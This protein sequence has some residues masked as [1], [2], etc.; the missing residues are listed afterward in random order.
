MRE[1]DAHVCTIYM[2][3]K[4]PNAYA[5]L[6]RAN[7]L[8]LSA[9]RWAYV[10][11]GFFPGG[12]FSRWAFVRIP[13][14]SLVGCYKNHCTVPKIYE[15]PCDSSKNL[16][17]FKMCVVILARIKNSLK[18]QIY[19]MKNHVILQK[20]NFFPNVCCDSCKNKKF[21]QESS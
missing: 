17:F 20:I 2:L 10:R 8:C 1:L 21:P 13:Q 4:F 6:Y 12:L 11:V 3:H 18:N 14:N 7:K 16:F 5:L 9:V 19:S 15:K